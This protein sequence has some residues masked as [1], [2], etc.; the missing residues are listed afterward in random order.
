MPPLGHSCRDVH[1]RP[2]ARVEVD[3]EV[4]GAEDL[5][6][7]G[8]IVDFVLTEGPCRCRSAEAARRDQRQKITECRR[9][10]KLDMPTSSVLPRGAGLTCET[11]QVPHQWQCA[12]LPRT[13]FY[14]VSGTVD[15]HCQWMVHTVVE[16]VQ[17]PR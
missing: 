16:T 4:I 15:A 3:V 8:T 1:A 5:E 6:I 10:L 13:G 14:V 7:E 11:V 9:N 2:L 12:A 17:Q